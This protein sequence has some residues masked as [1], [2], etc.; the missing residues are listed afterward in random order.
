L[1][2]NLINEFEGM[3]YVDDK[4]E[5]KEDNAKKLGEKLI[6]KTRARKNKNELNKKE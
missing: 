2:N 1:Q 3:E 4:W 6:K 5:Y